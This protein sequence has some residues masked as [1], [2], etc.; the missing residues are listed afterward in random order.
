MDLGRKGQGA[1]ALPGVRPV[2]RVTAQILGR[3]TL[4]LGKAILLTPHHH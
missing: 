2:S 4:I 1:E 3:N